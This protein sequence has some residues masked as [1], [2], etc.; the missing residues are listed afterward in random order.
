MRQNNTPIAIVLFLLFKVFAALLH[1]FFPAIRMEYDILICNTIT[2]ITFL[3]FRFIDVRKNFSVK[4]TTTFCISFPL[5][6]AAISGIIALNILTELINLPD[7]NATT[8]RSIIQTPSGIISVTILASITEEI[9]FRGIILTNA[10]RTGTS[11]WLAVICSSLVF[12]LIHINPIQIPFATAMGIILALTYL[13]TRTLIIPIIIHFCNNSLAV[14]S[15]I[16]AE[17]TG[18]EYSFTDAFGGETVAIMVAMVCIVMI[19]SIYIHY[20]IFHLNKFCYR[21]DET[22]IEY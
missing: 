8:I 22:D 15:V 20:G 10:L 19:I 13:H 18:H 14:I 5:I 9:V 2:L 1:T 7:L 16:L 4:N 11:A 21:S 12:G 17:K 6:I 3:S